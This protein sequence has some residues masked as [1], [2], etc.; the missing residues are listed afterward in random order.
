MDIYDH[1]TEKLIKAV[2]EKAKKIVIKRSDGGYDG[3]INVYKRKLTTK[4]QPTIGAVAFDLIGKIEK[5][6]AAIKRMDRDGKAPET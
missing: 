3:E 5:I 4:D 2:L 1:A 6:E